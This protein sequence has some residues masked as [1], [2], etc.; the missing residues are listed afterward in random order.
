MKRYPE[1]DRLRVECHNTGEINAPSQRRKVASASAWSWLTAESDVC[2]MHGNEAQ[3]VRWRCCCSWL[4][5]RRYTGAALLRQPKLLQ[6]GQG[7]RLGAA[8]A[9]EDQAKQLRTLRTACLCMCMFVH[10]CRAGLAFQEDLMSLRCLLHGHRLPML[11]R[12]PAIFHCQSISQVCSRSCR[13]TALRGSCQAL[14]PSCVSVR[15]S[16]SDAHGH[17]RAHKYCT[18]ASTTGDHLADIK[19]P[20]YCPGCGIKLQYDDASLPGYACWLSRLC[21]PWEHHLRVVNRV[22]RQLWQSL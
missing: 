14:P 21:A 11:L 12:Q 6:H 1:F 9:P 5:R 22:L 8:K 10:V 17:G 19:L 16:C 7:P 3:L 20:D 15:P 4:C 2:A 13:G 18:A